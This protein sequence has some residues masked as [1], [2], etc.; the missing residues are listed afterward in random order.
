[1][2][3]QADRQTPF[4][5]LRIRLY[6][7]YSDFSLRRST[8]FMATLRKLRLCPFLPQS[9]ALNFFA[10]LCDEHVGHFYNSIVSA[11]NQLRIVC[12]R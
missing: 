8:T 7:A 11:R 9:F 12:Q 6:T 5:I 3:A 2:D 1:M 4:A 10:F